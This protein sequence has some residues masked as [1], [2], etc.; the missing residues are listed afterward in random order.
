MVARHLRTGLQNWLA[1]AATKKAESR[2][3]LV[4]EILEDRLAPATLIETVY[5]LDLGSIPLQSNGNFGSATAVNSSFY[6]VSAPSADIGGVPHRGAAYVYSSTTGALLATLANPSTASNDGFGGLMSVS[7]SG[8]T[9]VVGANG[10]DDAGVSESGRAYVFDAPTGALIATLANPSPAP[11]DAFGRSVSVSGNMVVVGALGAPFGGQAYVF[12]A[13]TGALIATL[14]NPTPANGDQFGISVSLSGNTVVVGAIRDDT[15]ATDSGQAYVFNATTGV[16]IGTLANPTPASND[17]FGVAVSLSGNTVVVGASGATDSGQAYVFNVMTGALIATLDNPSST[18]GDLFGGWVSLS[19]N[20]VVV[21]AEFDDAGAM[22]SGQAYVFNATTGALIATLDN[23]SPA[24]GDHFSRV[25]ISGDTVVVGANADD[26]QGLDQGAA[27]VFSLG[28]GTNSPPV[29]TSVAPFVGPTA[30]GIT[31]VINGAHFL[32]VTGPAGVKFGANNATSYTVDSDTKITAVLPAGN[33]GSVNVIVTNAGL[34]SSTAGT[35]DDFQYTAPLPA[36]WSSAGNMARARSYTWTM[37]PLKNGQVLVTEGGAAGGATLSD[38]SA[39][40]YNSLTNTWTSAGSMATARGNQTAAT[41]LGNG[42]V[43]VAGGSDSSGILSSAE[44]YDPTSNTWSDAASMS[45]ARHSYCATLLANGKVLV[46]GGYGTGNNSLGNLS[47][48]ELYDPTNNTWTSAGS[49]ATARS[50]FRATLLGNGKVLVT[51]GFNGSYVSGAELY[52]PVSNIWSS[53]GSLTTARIRHTAT[54]LGNGKVLVAGGS[55]ASNAS[56][57]STELYDPLTNTWSTAS[58]MITPRDSGSA[59]LLGNGKVLVTGGSATRYVTGMQ[60]SAELYDPVNNTWS[61]T[62]S[63]ASIRDHHRA[64]LLNN[65][66]VLVAGGWDGSSSGGL[67]TSLSSAELYD[68]GLSMLI[69]TT[70]ALTATP[71][72]AI[73]GQLVTLI[74]TV[75]PSPGSLG[76]VTFIDNGGVLVASVPVV[77]GKSVIQLSSL[78]AGTHIIRADYSGNGGFAANTS[79]TLNFIVSVPTAPQVLSVTPNGNVPSLAGEQRSRVVSLVVS[80]NELVQLDAGAMTLALH[81]NNVSLEGVLQPA[82]VGS[83]PTSLGLSSTDNK[84]WIVTFVGNTDTGVDGLGSLKDGVYDLTIDAVKV[85]PLGAP[86]IT[87]AANRTTT[88]HRLFG[89]TGAPTTPPGGAPGTDFTAIL[90]TADNLAF[91]GAFNKPVGGGYQPFLDFNGD[92]II[93]TVDNLQF[94]S[95]FNKALTWKV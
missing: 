59:T 38:S 33:V 18:S 56:L 65:G 68:P 95:R 28:S 34:T 15:G 39:E 49:M 17:Y 40:L 10:F 54:L 12:N 9:V 85:H 25:S 22:D 87:M 47:S 74:A 61:A 79:N 92:G 35:A 2:R 1:L 48:A 71:N 60:S 27:Y 5:P 3:L 91:R 72:A 69:P 46:E 64:T 6:V 58:S 81:T 90:N 8:N 16:L 62:A 26:T 76:T 32:G 80:F 36:S 94:R 31:V 55:D 84:N 41:L 37:T 57:S 78:A 53:A 42:K 19:E 82:G 63:M 7:L 93:N 44:L 23:P 20:T 50:G 21:G 67:L 30:G 14:A 83:L 11:L 52:D 43:L 13:T 66:K 86:T 70:T 77:S 4:L 73:S 88:F 89:D 51:G 24:T 45:W 29:V 75:E